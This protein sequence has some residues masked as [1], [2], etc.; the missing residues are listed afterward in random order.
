MTF[1][2]RLLLAGQEPHDS[3]A[4]IEAAFVPEKDD[5]I[6]LRRP[7]EDEPTRY[8][9]TAR[10]LHVDEGSNEPPAIYLDVVD[11]KPKPGAWG[12]QS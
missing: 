8:V 2:I 5:Q 7:G 11:T 1:Q 4:T 3:F 6:V 9:V 10:R 12:T